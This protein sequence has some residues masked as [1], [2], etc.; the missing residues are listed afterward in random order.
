[1]RLAGSI[2]FR[3]FVWAS[4]IFAVSVGF[5]CQSESRSTHTEASTATDRGKGAYSDAMIH[6][7]TEHAKTAIE[8]AGERR[9]D[10]P[11]APRRREG[12]R[13]VDQPRI[14]PS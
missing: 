5:A 11:A 4:M 2:L 13:V 3:S 6:S 7:D 14:R 9:K 12:T 8:E 1:M 10:R